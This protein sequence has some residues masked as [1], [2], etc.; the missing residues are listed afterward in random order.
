M[1]KLWA[2]A[3][4]KGGQLPLFSHSRMAQSVPA[5]SCCFCRLLSVSLPSLGLMSPLHSP[6]VSSSALSFANL[7]RV[8]FISNPCIGLGPGHPRRVS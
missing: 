2:S 7:A 4:L 1:R 5:A 6:F 3:W 8:S